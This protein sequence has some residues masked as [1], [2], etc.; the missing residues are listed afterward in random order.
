MT[1]PLEKLALERFRP[2]LLRL[3]SARIESC[4]ERLA[5]L[6]GRYG[7]TPRAEN[8]EQSLW[9]ARDAVLITYGDMVQSQNA[10]PLET[11]E[12]FLR[13][14]V[15]DAF[16]TLHLLPFFPYSSDDGFSV[17]HFRR[18]DPALGSWQDVEKL[19]ASHRLMVDLVLN[20]VSRQSGWFRDFETGV[21]PGRD[22]FMTAD[23]A[24]DLSAVARPRTHPLLTP[25]QTRSGLRHVWTTFSADQ[26]DL[27]FSNPDVFFELLDI[28]LFYIAHGVRVIRLDAIA[29]LWK[30][31]G[32]SCLHLPE[33]HEVVKLFRAFLDIVA[34]GVVLLTET[35]VPHVENISYFGAGDEAHMVYQFPLPPLILHALLNGSAERLSAWADAL[36]PPP[37]GCAFLNFTASHDGIGVRPLQGLIPNHELDALA[38]AVRL[39]GGSV[40]MKRNADGSESPYELN[41]TY[42]DALGGGNPEQQFARFLCS[43]TIPLALQGVPA[44]YFQSLV[45][46]P[47]D[48]AGVRRTK[49]ARSINRHKWQEQE[50]ASLL[51]DTTSPAARFMPELLR[52]LQLRKQCPAFDPATPQH[53]HQLDPGVFAVE[54][55]HADTPLLALHNV[56]DQPRRVHLPTG[57]AEDGWTDLLAATRVSSRDREA[58]L[59]PYACR[60]IV[61][62]HSLRNASA[63]EMRAA[64]RAGA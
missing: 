29:F 41:I 48:E 53:I 43:Q 16:S 3:Y 33:T 10:P 45:A 62:D 60:W 22:Y 44:V 42:F 9:T 1:S 36:P 38:E 63:G 35:N 17:I 5:L 27:D 25:V 37:P 4:M 57:F 64:A 13:Q 32:T 47:N 18:V 31:P 55:L 51:H 2:G 7:P 46:A 59:A 28:L 19:G 15:G 52:R 39:R 23:P 34:P 24:T 6:A 58:L 56:S 21:A 61:N 14:Y 49:A 8:S 54:R 26:V 20:H 40:S 12:R 50:L 11:L 30:K